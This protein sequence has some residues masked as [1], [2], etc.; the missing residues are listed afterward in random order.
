MRTWAFAAPAAALGVLCAARPASAQ[1]TTNPRFGDAGQ[2]VVSSDAQGSLQV[3]TY[4]DGSPSVTA[5][6]LAPAADLF[7]VRSLSVGA[8]LSWTHTQSSGVP[9][10]DSW[11]T[12]LRVGYS[13]AMGPSFSF[14]PKVNVDYRHTSLV[15]T[16]LSMLQ[17]GV[18]SSEYSFDSMVIGVFAPVVFHPVPHFFLGL[19]P[20]FQAAVLSSAGTD[21]SYGLMFTL[22]GWFSLV[23]G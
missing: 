21:A 22:G 14:W 9:N 1:P 7:L 16:D 10:T 13:L 8:H 23:G 18:T 3:Q 12:G 19:G 20:N 6:T 17:Q 2:L 15:T 5:I 11:S 4:S